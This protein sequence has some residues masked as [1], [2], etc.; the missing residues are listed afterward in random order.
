MWGQ[1]SKSLFNPLSDPDQIEIPN[2]I[3]IQSTTN[4]KSN[5]KF[6]NRIF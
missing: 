5:E 3:K 6:M 4:Q 2:L 1:V